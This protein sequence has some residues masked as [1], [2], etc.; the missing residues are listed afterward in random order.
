MFTFNRRQE[1]WEKSNSTQSLWIYMKIS[2]TDKT[3]AE[4]QLIAGE[5]YGR[6]FRIIQDQ[7]RSLIGR[8]ELLLFHSVLEDLIR[9]WRTEM[10]R[11]KWDTK[12]S[13]EKEINLRYFALS[14]DIGF[15]EKYMELLNKKQI[16]RG[17]KK[18]AY[19][20]K[21]EYM[22]KDKTSNG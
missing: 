20:Q 22:T 6:V 15:L 12:R 11:N 10:R 2:Q 13:Y 7:N 17:G 4:K 18:L 5:V 19:I 16:G 3:V 9:S 8:M 1:I 14:D 21:S